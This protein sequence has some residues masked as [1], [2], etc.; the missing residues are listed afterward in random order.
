MKN[1]RGFTLIEVMVAVAVFALAMALAYGGLNSIIDARRQ[2]DQE[3]ESV[4]KLQFAVGLLERDLRSV[5]Q[6]PVLDRYG[7]RQPALTLQGGRLLLTRGGYSNTLAA[8]RAEL[9]RVEWSWRDQ[10]LQRE[11][12]PQLDSASS[13]T[14]PP[15]EVMSD[16]D[17]VV[18]EALTPD[19][20]W[21]DRWPRVGQPGD[22]LPKAVRVRVLNAKFGQ[23]ERV[24]ELAAPDASAAP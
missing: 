13:P 23:V 14:E 1:T 24:F 12:M 6:R 16:V 7:Q 22:L 5:V 9:Q 4:A 18:F 19:L 15:F 10:T 2:L 8:S 11:A 20:R 3:S 17:Q 21:S